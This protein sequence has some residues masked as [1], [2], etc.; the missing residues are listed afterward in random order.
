MERCPEF[1]TQDLHTLIL[2][3][4]FK[5]AKGLREFLFKE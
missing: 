5:P 1:V 3:I 2:D 4:K